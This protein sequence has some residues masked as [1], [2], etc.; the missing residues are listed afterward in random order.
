M[1]YEN[2]HGMIELILLCSW[3]ENE[4]MKKVKILQADQAVSLVK[5]GDTL[6]TCGFVGN[7][8]PEALNKAMEK[9][10][11]ETGSPRGLTLF[12]PGSQGDKSG[13]YGGD[14]YAHEGLLKRVVAG[15]YATAQKLQELC[16]SNKYKTYNL[17]QGVLSSLFREIA[18]PQARHHYPCGAG[19]VCGPEKR[20]RQD[21]RKNQ[22]R[23]S[24]GHR[25]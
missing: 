15:H 7:C 4:Q 14:H 9:R 12:Y 18:R 25:I 22:G 24:E 16:L 11:L 20:G 1:V 5:D 13:V 19:H 3:R 21:Q 2:A 23:F 17:P 6:V 10:F 8:I